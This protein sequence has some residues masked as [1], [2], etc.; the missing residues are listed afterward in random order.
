M[1]GQITISLSNLINVIAIILSIIAL[2]ITIIGFFASLKFY[3]DG[4]KLQG[5]AN[6]AMIMIKEK[7]E[8]IQLQVGGMFDKTLDAALNRSNQMSES[9]EEINTQMEQTSA[10]IVEAALKEI[11]TASK[12]E[13]EKIKQIVD[14]QMNLVKE[15]LQSTREEAESMAYSAIDYMPRSNFQAQILSHLLGAKN[16]VSLSDLSTVVNTNTI[17]TE[18]AVDRLVDRGIIEIKKDKG[19][20]YYKAKIKN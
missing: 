17:T 4:V 3:R 2:F 18:K 6:D 9:F 7:T 11:G 16:W 20:N 12:K 10:S 5:I 1:D 8:A 19:D 13:K 14:E 15:R